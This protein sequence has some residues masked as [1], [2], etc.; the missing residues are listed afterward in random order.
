MCAVFV[1]LNPTVVGSRDC[2]VINR[3]YRARQHAIHAESDIV[4][5]NPSVRP[6]VRLI[7]VLYLNECIYLPTISTV[8]RHD[9]SSYRCLNHYNGNSI[10]RRAR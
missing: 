4:L 3:F 1:L 7:V 9:P 10:R 2:L 8:W 6:S 5:A